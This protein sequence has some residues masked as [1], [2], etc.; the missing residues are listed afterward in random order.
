MK[1]SGIFIL[2]VQVERELGLGVRG[3]FRVD[4]KGLVE[5]VVEFVVGG[6]CWEG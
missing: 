1:A 6:G 5:I 3:L 2:G 4:E